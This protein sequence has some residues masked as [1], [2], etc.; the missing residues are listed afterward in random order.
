[1]ICPEDGDRVEP[2]PTVR[3]EE[4]DAAGQRSESF[5]IRPN[6]ALAATKSQSHEAPQRSGGRRG[7]VDQLS[8][9][10]VRIIHFREDF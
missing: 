9:H 8:L 10:S 5:R 3:I 2:V 4:L 1:M 7:I 6:A